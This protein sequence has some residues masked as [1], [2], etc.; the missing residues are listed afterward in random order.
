MEYKFLI[1][2]FLWET[3]DSLLETIQDTE[4]SKFKYP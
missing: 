3:E 2:K 4:D 1:I